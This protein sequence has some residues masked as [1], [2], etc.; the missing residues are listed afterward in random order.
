MKYWSILIFLAIPWNI[1]AQDINCID[2]RSRESRCLS[3][4]VLDLN[5]HTLAIDITDDFRSNFYMAEYRF[6]SLTMIFNDSFNNNHFNFA[7]PIFPILAVSGAFNN[8]HEFGIKN[9]FFFL[10]GSQHYLYLWNE[11]Y[12]KKF[13]RS[14]WISLFY[15]QNIEWFA[16]RKNQWI[17]FSPT[18]GICLNYIDNKSLLFDERAR[19]SLEF[20]YSKNI[21]TDFKVLRSSNTYLLSLKLYGPAIF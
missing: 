11:P 12:T 8:I 4:E 2:E 1:E 9:I 6:G 7:F 18:I 17:D 13:Q 5:K 10:L 19:L 14:Q 15:K 16:F 3:Y 20:G 21:S